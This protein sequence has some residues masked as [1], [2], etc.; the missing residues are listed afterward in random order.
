MPRTGR[1]IVEG[2]MMPAEREALHEEVL[3]NRPAHVLEVGCWRGGGS[4]YQIATALKK[5][6]GGKLHTCETDKETI[7]RAYGAFQQTDLW[8]LVD[9]HPL[10]SHVLIQNLLAKGVIPNFI[11]FDGPEDPNVAMQDFQTLDAVVPS[12][13]IFSM[14]DWLHDLSTK[15]KLLKPYLEGL[16]T[17]KIYRLLVLPVSVGLVFARKL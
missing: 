13:T 4:T 10:P 2:Q 5:L 17:W 16:A 15:Q 12:G 14:H 3:A 1:P 11:F 8:P 6:G 7:D 9:F